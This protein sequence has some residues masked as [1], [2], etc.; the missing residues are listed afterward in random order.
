MRAV[1]AHCWQGAPGVGWYP[2]AAQALAEQGHEVRVPLLPD[3]PCLEAWLLERQVS[4]RLAA[5]VV[6]WAARFA[7]AVA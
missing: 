2:R 6:A 1:I 5:E 3:A 4:Q 7:V